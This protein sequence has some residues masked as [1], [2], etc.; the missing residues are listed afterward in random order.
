[1]CHGCRCAVLRIQWLLP[2]CTDCTPL[3]PLLALWCTGILT[4]CARLTDTRAVADVPGNLLGI[5]V[6]A[7]AGA[8]GHKPIALLG[9]ATGRVGDPSGRSSERPVLSE[10]EINSNVE[11]ARGLSAT[12][13][14]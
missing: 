6:L 13:A 3:P 7:W 14:T 11:G 12:M 1:M 10:D 2:C 8:C 5:I 4:L 9:G